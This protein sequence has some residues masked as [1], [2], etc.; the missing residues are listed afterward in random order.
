MSQNN[1]T[2]LPQ[3]THDLRN[4]IGGISGL[5]EIISQN[6]NDYLAK[7]KQQGV[8]IDENLKKISEYANILTPYS[9]EA[10]CYIEDLLNNSQME[11]GRFTLGTVENCDVEKVVK[12]LLVFNQSFI[13]EHKIIVETD[14][15]EDL[16]KLEIDVLRFK[17]I[18][19]NLITN[20]AKYSYEGGKVNIIIKTMNHNHE[21]QIQ[22]IILDSGI[23]MTEEEIAMAFNG[24][25]QNIDK[26]SL[27]KPIDSH[28]L[29][30]PVVKQL[31]ELLKAKMEIESCK[32]RGTKISLC[33]AYD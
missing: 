27:N 8:E 9:D 13:E 18:L 15:E 23:G 6:I 29:G 24:D 32:E 12:E 31:V 14:I 33:F 26:S 19:I 11:F 7:Q 16:P 28:G 21:K 30:M 2:L 22:I 10:M 5:A 17:Q 20:A 4:Y 25:G 1:Q 3:I